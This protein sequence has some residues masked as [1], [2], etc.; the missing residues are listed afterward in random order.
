MKFLFILFAL[1]SLQVN[2]KAIGELP[3]NSGGKIIFT[4]DVCQYHPAARRVYSYSGTGNTME[5]CWFIEDE[6]V[7]VRYEDIKQPY[8]YP[9][10][11]VLTPSK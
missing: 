2:A 11:K 3:N 1:I 6:T 8:R 10:N 9:L 5:G 4:D 7:V